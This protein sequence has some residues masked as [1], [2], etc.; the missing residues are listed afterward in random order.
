MRNQVRL[1]ERASAFERRSGTSRANF[2]S[3]LRSEARTRMR[4]LATLCHFE[5]ALRLRNLSLW[6][7]I[8]HFARNDREG[9]LEM[10]GRK[11]V[12]IT[13]RKEVKMTVT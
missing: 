8:S 13:G 9:R 7:K 6:V 12:E 1:I 4:R 3:F 2:L 5:G 10:R 11:V